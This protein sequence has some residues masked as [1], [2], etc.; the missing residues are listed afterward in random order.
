ME[1]RCAADEPENYKNYKTNKPPVHCTGTGGSFLSDRGSLE[2]T[3][4]DGAIF[5]GQADNDHL[6]AFGHIRRV[7]GHIWLEMIFC[8][9]L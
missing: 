8:S 6:P 5:I 3:F 9:F 4:H 7:R 1:R 2:H